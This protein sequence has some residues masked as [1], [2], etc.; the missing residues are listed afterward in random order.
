M[1]VSAPGSRVV[2]ITGAAQGIGAA[3]AWRFAEDG[4]RVVL[5]D[6]APDGAAEAAAKIAATHPGSGAIGLRT[7]VTDASAC[8]E[9]VATTVAR[10]GRLDVLAVA[11]VVAPPWS[12][13]KDLPPAEW[14]RVLAVN[15]KGPFLL[16]RRAIP[17]PRRAAA[18]STSTPD[19]RSSAHRDEPS[20]APPRE[21]SVR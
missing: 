20:T 17:A 15:A 2:I 16:S 18:S 19:T 4:A 14:D 21:R 9:L 7:D 13:L 6:M 8:D 5:T 12:P 10:H 11:T 3:A 1:P